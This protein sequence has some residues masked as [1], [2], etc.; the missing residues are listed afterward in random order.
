M[1][2]DARGIA[3]TDWDGDGDLDLWVANR[4]GPQLRFFRNTSDTE[5]NSVVLALEGTTCNRDAIGARITCRI[6]NAEKESQQNATLVRTVRA[7]QRI[8]EPIQQVRSF[9]FRE[10]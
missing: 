8:P 6:N 1:P 4:S 5:H 2:D 10:D 9:W 7:R 3:T